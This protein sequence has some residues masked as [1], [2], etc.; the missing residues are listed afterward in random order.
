MCFTTRLLMGL[1]VLAC[2]LPVVASVSFGQEDVTYQLEYFASSPD[3]VIVIRVSADHQALFDRVVLDLGQSTYDKPT[4]QLLADYGST[5]TPAEDRAQEVLYFQFGRYLLIASSRNGSLPANLQ[6]VW[7]H[8]ETPP[9]NADYHVNINL[10]MSYWPEEVTNLSETTG[11]LFDFVDALVKPGRRSARQ[12]YGADG[13]TL[14]LNTN[15][16]GFVGVID[17]PTAFW[18][19]E[20]GAWRAQHYYEHYLFNRNREFLERL[21][22]GLKIGRWDQPQEWHADLDDPEKIPRPVP[23]LFALHPGRQITAEQSALLETTKT[24]LNARG[25]GGTG[26]A[27]AWK[28]NLW[29]RLLEGDRAGFSGSNSRSAGPTSID[30]AVNH[31]QSRTRP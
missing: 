9:W 29:A 11:P 10:Q 20:A 27:Q 25:D 7:N 5:N 19:P 22:P 4:P 28:I 15:I 26:S 16:W 14:L 18:Q 31:F 1:T 3:Q 30:F 21:N 17:W 2:A 12:F 24:T 8:S 6:G 23:H 13:W